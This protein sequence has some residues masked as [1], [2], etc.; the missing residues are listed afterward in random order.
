MGSMGLVWVFPKIGVFPP[1]WMV[2]ME[3]LFEMDDLGVPL[4]LE[5]TVYLS[6]F[7]IKKKSTK[8][9]GKQTSH[10]D[11]IGNIFITRAFSSG[12]F[13]I[14][15]P[16]KQPEIARVLL[17]LLCFMDELYLSN[18]KQN[19]WLPFHEILITG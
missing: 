12:A 4:F 1:K 19:P 5:T 7:T 3:N 8:L 13:F 18:V 6:P 2:L 17:N 16:F 10:L 15:Q 14:P 11:C 9:V